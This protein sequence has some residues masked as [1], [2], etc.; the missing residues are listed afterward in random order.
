LS[1]TSVLGD[2][3]ISRL[4]LFMALSRTPHGVLDMA[5][6]ALAALLYL[7]TVP[8]LPVVLLG[9]LTA[10]AGYTAVYALNDVVDYRVDREKVR[11]CGLPDAG[12]DLD[13]VCARHPMAQGL[14][15]LREGI[16]WTVFWGA[17]ALAGAYLLNPVCALI[18]MGGCAAEAVYCL[19]L[20]V[21]YLRTVVSG[22][23][24]TAGGLA[25]I[26][27]VA[28]E[29]SPLFVLVFFLW[30]FAWEIGGQ[31]IP[32][33]WADMKEDQEL[34]TDT[35]PVRFGVDVSLRIIVAA[36]AASVLLSLALYWITPAR[37]SPAYLLGAIGA[38]GLLLLHPVRRLKTRR[39]AAS[40]SSLFNRAST[41]PLA[42]FLVVLVS[43]ILA[44][45]G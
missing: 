20:R 23:V 36:L 22:V 3:G 8:P 24:K 35:I 26:F 27:A 29:P 28:P 31:N 1:T 38:G 45:L 19:M 33:D 5:T 39:D 11:H 18:F 4:K 21:S 41:Y 14:L 12:G 2:P 42:L 30:L 17:V 44:R 10:F 7:G 25:A 6:P 32:N 40:A 9:I 37:L 34:Q 13:A 43:A 15:S 16:A